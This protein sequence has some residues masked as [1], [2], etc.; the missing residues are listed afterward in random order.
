MPLTDT[1]IRKMKPESKRYRKTDSD[2]L[3]I[4]VT[5]NNKKIWR[6]RYQFAGKS[7]IFTIG[8]YPAISLKKARELRDQ[9]KALVLQGINPTEYK[10]TKIAQQQAELEHQQVQ[11]NRMTFAGLFE[12]WHAHNA[13]NWTYDYAK[14]IRERVEAH[15][16][17][18]LGNQPLEEIK[19]KDIINALKQI[20]AKGIMET[21]KRTKQY[22]SRIFRYGVGMGHCETDPVRDLPTDI[23]KKQ[24]KDNFNHITDR[25]E[26]SQ[27]LRA[28]DTYL[29]DISTATALKLAP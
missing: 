13:E 6:Y 11:A 26:L 24:D 10:K 5:P 17:P 4:E 15:L 8:D 22:A 18:V 7:A 19:P 25:G 20:E 3:I 2:G 21:M 14:D 12:L 9:A 23:F 28:I 1:A 29:G 16:I 27:L